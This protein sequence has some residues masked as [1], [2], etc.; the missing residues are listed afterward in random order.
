MWRLNGK[1]NEFK[2]VGFN[3]TFAFQHHARVRSQNAS[4]TTISIFDN[5]S[6]G[7]NTTSLYSSGMVMSVNTDA[8]ARGI[9][10]YCQTQ[11]SS[12]AGVVDPT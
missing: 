8:L 4:T 2:F 3:N 12:W 7:E 5:G 10:S 1:K 6:D 11:M 9:R